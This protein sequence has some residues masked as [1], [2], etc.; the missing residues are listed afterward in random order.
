MNDYKKKVLKNTA[1]GTALGSA[2]G[3]GAGYLGGHRGTDLA[4]DALS[5]GVSGGTLGG[6]GTMALK[7]YRDN[8]VPYTLAS[9][10]LRNPSLAK[11]LQDNASAAAKRTQNL[12][13]INAGL[14]QQIRNKRNSF[15]KSSSLG[16]KRYIAGKG[17]LGALVGAG[18]G[19]GA[20]YYNSKGDIGRTL[21]G[22]AM[23]GSVGGTAGTL[24]GIKQNRDKFDEKSRPLRDAMKREHENLGKERGEM[25]WNRVLKRD[26]DRL[27]NV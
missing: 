19:G 12:K 25:M 11:D 2:I 17:A 6:G 1:I 9:E 14:K 18:I 8:N 21:R 22:A 4:I 26:L 13:K 24:L 27:N 16:R 23:G 10:H 7:E 20:E 15:F 5:G 3:A